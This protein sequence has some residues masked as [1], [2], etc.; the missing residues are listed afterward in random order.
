MSLASCSDASSQWLKARLGPPGGAY[1]R[2]SPLYHKLLPTIVAQRWFTPL[3]PA[4]DRPSWERQ[5]G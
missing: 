1:R 2:D 5:I 4:K 3:K